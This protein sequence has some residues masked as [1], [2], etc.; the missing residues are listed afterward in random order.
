ME[1]KIVPMIARGQRVIRPLTL[2]GAQTEMETE[3]PTSTTRG[4]SAIP[5]SK[6]SSPPV[7][8]MIT[9]AWITRQAES[10]SSRVR[11]MVSYEFGMQAR[12]QTFVLSTQLPMS[13]GLIFRLT[14][15]MLLPLLTTTPST[16]TTAQTSL[17]CTEASAL[18]L[19]E[20]TR[21]MRLNSHPTVP[22]SPWP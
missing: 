7:Q 8:A 9:T 6:T 18:M 14:A 15:I 10:S 16:S 21:S 19:E 17:P 1:C 22:A 4:P 2:M 11:R 5:I 3:R 12:G 20:E 13:T